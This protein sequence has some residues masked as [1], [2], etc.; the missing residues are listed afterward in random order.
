M[1]E[2][3][4]NF[5]IFLILFMLSFSLPKFLL[6]FGVKLLFMLLIAF[7]SPVIQNQTPYEHLFGS[8]LDYHHLRSFD[9]ACFVLLQPHEHNKLEPR[10]RFCCFLGYG[11]TQKGYQCYDPISHR[12]CIS[13][14]VVFWEYRLFV[15]LSHFRA[16]LSSFSILDLF[17]K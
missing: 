9:S 14:N 5:V 4:E 3:N 12:L 6:L 2:P 1:V 13:C 15:E 8:P 17:S 7:P 10:S 11:E 16:S